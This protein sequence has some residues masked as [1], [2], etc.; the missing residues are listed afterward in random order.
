MPCSHRAPPSR[1][2][3]GSSPQTAAALRDSPPAGPELVLVCAPSCPQF[4]A[5]PAS[6][7]GN[8]AVAP[9]IVG[10]D[11]H[12]VSELF[13][14]RQLADELQDFRNVVRRRRAYV[15]HSPIITAFGGAVVSSRLLKRRTRA[16]FSLPILMRVPRDLIGSAGTSQQ[17]VSARKLVRGTDDFTG[18][19]PDARKF[20]RALRTPETPRSYNGGVFQ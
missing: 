3:R 2:G 4:T 6:S 17:D 19:M 11:H 20:H 15:Q 12:Q 18:M 14:L 8:P 9:D 10:R 1:T 16:L 7:T 13:V 5:N